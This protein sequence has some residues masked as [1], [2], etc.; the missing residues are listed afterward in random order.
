MP[1]HTRDHHINRQNC[2]ACQPQQ[3]APLPPHVC[4]VW[5]WDAR[6]GVSYCRDCGAVPARRKSA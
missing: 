1:E 2:P 6:R 4:S 3:W 5:Q